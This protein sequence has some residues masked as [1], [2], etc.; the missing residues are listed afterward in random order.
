MAERSSDSPG[1]DILRRWIEAQQAAFTRGPGHAWAQA[2]ALHEAW[3]RFAESFADARA[4]RHGGPGASPFDPAGW[5]RAEGEGGMADL[6]RWLEGPEFSDLW[7]EQRRAIRETR[8]WM[9]YLT[10]LE[11]M[12]AVL[13][14]G[15][16]A[17]FR[18]FAE[19]LAE[20]PGGDDGPRWPE[21]VALWQEVAGEETDRLYRSAPYLAASRD[22][23]RAEAALRRALRARA[24]VLSDLLGL[25]TRAELDDLHETVHRL[26]RELRALRAAVGRSPAGSPGR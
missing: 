13:G 9:A 21:I 10:A 15:W 23:V 19:R 2:E 4:E 8:E 16:L 3:A 18:R 6:M 12:K 20:M 14:Q 1:F 7:A 26:R 5:L 24:E 17:A 22:L 25:P 11:Q